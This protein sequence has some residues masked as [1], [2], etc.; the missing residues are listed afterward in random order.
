MILR[1]RETR[2]LLLV[3]LIIFH[4][5]GHSTVRNA[6]QKS[7]DEILVFLVGKNS[8]HNTANEELFFQILTL[9]QSGKNGHSQQRDKTDRL[10]ESWYET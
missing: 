6:V 10:G 1:Y 2:R 5:T 8:S 9:T 7:L 3:F 4:A